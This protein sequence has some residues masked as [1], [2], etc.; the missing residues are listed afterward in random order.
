MASEMDHPLIWPP[1]ALPDQVVK[2]GKFRTNEEEAA[3]TGYFW[4][5]DF[6]PV[7]EVGHVTCGIF[8]AA[9]SRSGG[10]AC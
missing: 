1:R 7:Q 4:V 8:T 10:I 9:V 2:V 6:L 3:A 5:L